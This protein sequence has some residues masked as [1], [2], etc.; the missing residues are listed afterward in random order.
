M[1]KN[2]RGKNDTFWLFE[3]ESQWEW[4]RQSPEEKPYAAVALCS[5]TK[6]IGG[7][8]AKLFWTA[9]KVTHTG[10]KKMW[11]R[12]GF[13]A[14][15]RIFKDLKNLA[16]KSGIASKSIVLWLCANSEVVRVLGV[17]VE[18]IF[19]R[20]KKDEFQGVWCCS[21]GSWQWNVRTRIF[22]AQYCFFTW[23]SCDTNCF[24]RRLLSL[25]PSIDSLAW[26]AELLGQI[27]AHI[28]DEMYAWVQMQVVSKA[29]RLE[30][31]R[32]PYDYLCNMQG[33]FIVQFDVPKKSWITLFA[34][35]VGGSSLGQLRKLRC[36]VE[37]GRAPFML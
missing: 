32:N 7:L 3:K 4:N 29:N 2:I 17:Q 28:S 27:N 13:F 6:S 34:W 26:M 23:S 25:R 10:S 37:Y 30:I 33:C 5:K 15:R 36:N 1:S 19:C 35:M 16:K 24:L 21:L 14:W 20:V 22:C 18:N 8:S 31:Q 12:R 9:A 11:D